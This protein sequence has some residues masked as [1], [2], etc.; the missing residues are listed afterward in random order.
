MSR[1]NSIVL[2]SLGLALIGCGPQAKEPTL[3]KFIQDHVATVRPLAI[4][5]NLADWEAA[6]TG[7]SEAYDKAGKLTQM[8]TFTAFQE[9]VGH[10]WETKGSLVQYDSGKKLRF[11]IE[12]AKA[13]TNIPDDVFA[14]PKT[15]SVQGDEK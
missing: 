4:Q 8:S 9:I 6:T 10:W 13:D 15:F 1:I 12:D 14:K 5:S 3:D 2:C 7:K 11:D